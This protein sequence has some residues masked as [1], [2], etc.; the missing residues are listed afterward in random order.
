MDMS[1]QA[2][3]PPERCTWLVQVASGHPEPDF[4]SDLWVEIECGAAVTSNEFGSFSCEAGHR[5]VS[6]SDPARADFELELIEWE[7]RLDNDSQFG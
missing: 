4:P 6:Y 1:T 7:K 5:H 3:L 2:L